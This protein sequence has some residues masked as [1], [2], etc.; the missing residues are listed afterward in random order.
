[1]YAWKRRCQ[2]CHEEYSPLARS[3]AKFC[4]NA[5]RQAMYRKRI[6]EIKRLRDRQIKHTRHVNPDC[7]ENPPI[8]EKPTSQDRPGST[9]TGPGD[10]LATAPGDLSEDAAANATA[11]ALKLREYSPS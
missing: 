2:N 7:E 11:A 5:C 10:S 9:I 4:S 1:M 8:G 6:A 3:D